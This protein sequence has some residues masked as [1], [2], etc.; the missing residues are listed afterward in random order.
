ML[1]FL[2]SRTFGFGRERDEGHGGEDSAPSPEGRER[3]GGLGGRGLSSSGGSGLRG[4]TKRRYAL[5]LSVSAVNALNHV[6]LAPPIGVL[7]SPLFGQSIS[8]AG[9]QFSAQVGNP[10]ANRL[11]YVGAALS[12]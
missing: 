10:A 5:T 12:F 3:D 2:L 4:A 1:N 8:L 7:S 6:N 9:G 11:I